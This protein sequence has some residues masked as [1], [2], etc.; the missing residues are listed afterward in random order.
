MENQVKRCPDE[1]TLR[2]SRHLCHYGKYIYARFKLRRRKHLINF[3]SQINK[4]KVLLFI[5]YHRFR[6][7]MAAAQQ[8][9]WIIFIIWTTTAFCVFSIS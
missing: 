7:A 6:R 9:R 2:T 5:P 8:F 4:A 3:I 1:N